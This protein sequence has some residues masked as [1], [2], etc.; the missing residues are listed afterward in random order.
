ME[1][2]D[3]ERLSQAFQCQMSCLLKDILTSGTAVKSLSDSVSTHCTHFYRLY[4]E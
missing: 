2:G 4:T 3:E 1:G